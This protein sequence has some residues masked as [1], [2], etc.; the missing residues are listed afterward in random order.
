VSRDES[1]AVFRLR[2]VSLL[3][4]LLLLL[5]WRRCARGLYK[6]GCGCVW[7]CSALVFVVVKEGREEVAERRKGF[8]KKGFVSLLSL[9]FFFF[10]TFF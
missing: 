4:L 8:S 2:G 1:A 9:F 7:S 5:M 3:L 10:E 6:S